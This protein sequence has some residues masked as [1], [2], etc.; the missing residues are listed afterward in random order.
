MSLILGIESDRRQAMH[1]TQ[2][3]RRLGAELILA[4]TFEGALPAVGSRVPDLIL[5]PAL[6][7]PEDE[8][9]LK[10]VLRTI[11][12][13]G[14]VQVL[15]TPLF[16]ALPRRSSARG[17]LPKFLRG[18]DDESVG[19]SEHDE[20]AHHIASYLQEAA[21]KR[22]SAP[23]NPP[24]VVD[25]I[26]PPVLMPSSPSTVDEEGFKRLI[27]ELSLLFA[28]VGTTFGAQADPSSP[29]TARSSTHGDEWGL[30][31]PKRCGVE[32]LI[33]KLREADESG[34]EI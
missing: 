10:F 27:G 20:F 33:A 31:D 2:I 16:A 17:M 29:A 23:V 30:F 6:L 9:S 12:G 15:T 22:A 13:A 8:S 18:R 34:Q 19:G 3:A 26:A 25:E 1:L 24:V 5:V 11:D 21:H 28:S 32:A 4:E 14:H 7:S